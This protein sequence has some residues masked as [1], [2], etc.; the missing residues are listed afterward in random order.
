MAEKTQGEKI[1]ET[2]E[3]DDVATAQSAIEQPAGDEPEQQN[4]GAR[5]EPTEMDDGAEVEAG[6]EDVRPKRATGKKAKSSAKKAPAT[7]QTVEVDAPPLE[8]SLG[9]LAQ[10]IAVVSVR[11]R[12]LQ[13]IDTAGTRFKNWLGSSTQVGRGKLLPGVRPSANSVQQIEVQL[14]QAD[15]EMTAAQARKELRALRSSR[16]SWMTVI[17]TAEETAREKQE[18]SAL[19]E[20][21]LKG[22][23]HWVSQFDRSYQWKVQARMDQQLAK[24]ESDLRAYE[25]SVR[26]VE[27]FEPGRLL[28]LRK[29]F[30]K[31]AGQPLL[32]VIPLALITLFLPVLFQIPKLD[33]LRT[34]YDPRLSAPII[35]LVVAAIVTSVLLIRRALGRDTIQNA[36]IAKWVVVA[37]I[38]GLFIVAM[39][40][41]EDAVRAD[42]IPFLEKYQWRILWI[43]AALVA[44]WTL[45]SL[46][47]YYQGWSQYR[48]GVENQ[49]AKLQAVI[50]GY[51]ETQQEVN[52]LSLLY[53]QVSEWLKILAHVLYRPWATHEEWQKSKNLSPEFND[54]PFSL[55]IAQVDDQSGA[56]SAELERIIASKLLVQ[57]WRADAFRDLVHH[58]AA[59]MGIGSDKLSTEQLDKDLPHQTN[60]TRNILRNYLE[61]SAKSM[62]NEPGN[63]DTKN[64]YLIEVARS[65][66]A[67][68]I[69]QTQS[70]ALSAARPSV[71]QIISNP[72]DAIQDDSA[73]LSSGD[74]SQNWDGFLKESLGTEEI[75]QPP[76]S[77]LNFTPEGQME[78][79]GE[80]SRT[81]VLIPQR[82][83]DALPEPT[84]G[85]EMVRVTDNSARAVEIIAR[86]D[87]AGPLKASS[88]RLFSK[89]APVVSRQ[90]AKAQMKETIA[91]PLC[92]NCHDPSCPASLDSRSRCAN[93]QF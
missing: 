19:S 18:A 53:E 78:K 28:E 15:D 73:A 69:E 49:L 82:L 23:S 56:K 14:E 40:V 90:R 67:E 85:I 45:L 68:L 91:Q 63:T 22:L 55:R 46:T 81:F 33:S 11:D 92:E 5:Q 58:V 2:N 75:V 36:T 12:Q 72:L 25:S 16:R 32:I 87:V 24:A 35:I 41:I 80:K 26:N 43:L 84:S 27:E 64:R 57:G 79:A 20:L 77:I 76:L 34:F 37:I 39:P 51:V 7:D 71:N 47:L 29:R 1:D 86:M 8:K 66:L 9:E 30:H 44:T 60:N 74:R 83:A 62:K 70:V 48:R 17:K 4:E 42:L 59:D 93:E 50:A 54:L 88:L 89:P 21:Q 31:I 13:Q 6:N 61:A 38:L 10:E 3:L 65:R 52:R